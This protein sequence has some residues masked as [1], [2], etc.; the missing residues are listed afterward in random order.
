R[1]IGVRLAI[2]DF[3]TG[4]SCLDYLRSF[5]VARLKIDRRFIDDMTTNPDNAIIV[6]ATISLAHELGIVV[7][8]EGIET[9]EQKA[10][11]ISIGCRIGQGYYLGRPLPADRASALLQSNRPW[12]K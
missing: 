2:D 8:A 7:V 3:G 9:A 5:H 10:Y 11:L 6:R 12:V 1:R 4:Y